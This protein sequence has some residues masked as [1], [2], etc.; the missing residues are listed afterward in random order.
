[1]PAAAGTSDGGDVDAE[2]VS[3]GDVADGTGS[4]CGVARPV[5]SPVVRDNGNQKVVGVSDG[6]PRNHHVIG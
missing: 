1:M 4:V 3:T 5:G 6:V 2:R